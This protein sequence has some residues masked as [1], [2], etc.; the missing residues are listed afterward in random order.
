MRININKYLGK[1]HEI[2]RI[3]SFFQFRMKD[4]TAEYT[5]NDDGTISVVNSGMIDGEYKEIKG[6]AIATDNDDTL[7]VT[8]FPN[9][10]SDYKIL[11]IDKD[12]QYSLVGGKTSDYL[13]ILSRSKTI[14]KLIFDKFIEIA[15]NK[16]YN[17]DKLIIT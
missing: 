8:F 13:W 1:W 7:K 10:Y 3:N 14:P 17:V 15:K 5:M 2:A 9:V 12:Y 4:V 6:V 11:A 16:K